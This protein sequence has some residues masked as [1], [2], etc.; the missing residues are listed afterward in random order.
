[1]GAKKEAV[2]AGAAIGTAVMLGVPFL[3]PVVWAG[4]L[5]TEHGLK[6]AGG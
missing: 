1:M 6:K 3:A 4:L 5:A 2:R